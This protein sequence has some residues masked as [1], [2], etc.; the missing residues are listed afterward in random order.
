MELSKDTRLNLRVVKPDFPIR[1]WVFPELPGKL[2]APPWQLYAGLTALILIL[3]FTGYRIR[4]YYHPLTVRLSNSPA[5]IITLDIR[6]LPAA[7]KLLSKARRIDTVL[8]E[9]GVHRQWPA[10]YF[11]MGGRQ[12]GKSTLLKALERRYQNDPLTDCRYIALHSEEIAPD[13]AEHAGLDAR[14]DLAEIIIKLREE[15][16]VNRRLFLINEADAFIRHEAA[17]GYAVLQQLRRLSETGKCH[18][19]LAG[20]W[21]LYRIASIDY[22]SPLKNFGE[23][24]TIGALEKEACRDLAV[25]PMALLNIGYTS[26]ELVE[27]MIVETGERANLLAIVCNEMLRNLAKTERTLQEADVLKALESDAVLTALAGWEG[28]TGNE[29]FDRMDRIVVYAGIL[30]ECF[31]IEGIMTF[32]DES[33]CRYEPQHLRESLLRLE[34]A[35]VL[36]KDK[37]KGAWSFCVPLF[38]KMINEWN[39]KRILEAEKRG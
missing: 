24:I 18:F 30:L 4:I 29:T 5:D 11:I 38:V 16:S 2:A 15:P 7:L 37:G 31:T 25:K 32:L 6:E 20:F 22:Q 36:K 10:N 17:T 34:L 39:P 14:A 8:T 3:F 13:L 26:D 28:I 33:G 12:L 9:A 19:I 21:E 23:M 35:F 1:E 27:R